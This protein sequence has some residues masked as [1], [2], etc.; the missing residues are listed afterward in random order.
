M[1]VSSPFKPKTKFSPNGTEKGEKDKVCMFFINFNVFQIKD[2]PFIL[3]SSASYIVIKKY[4]P[5][6]GM[7]MVD[8][9]FVFDVLVR[10]NRISSLVS[11]PCVET[12]DLV[13]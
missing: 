11:A 12:P 10:Q 4:P 5:F 7:M 2:L 1:Q 13:L 8:G 6:C 3:L 9:D